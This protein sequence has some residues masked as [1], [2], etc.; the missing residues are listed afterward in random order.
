MMDHSDTSINEVYLLRIIIH[1]WR[2]SWTSYE[3]ILI[4]TRIYWKYDNRF[5]FRFLNFTRKSFLPNHTDET[6]LTLRFFPL[7]YSILLVTFFEAVSSIF[8]SPGTGCSA[9]LETA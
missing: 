9:H 7:S 4:F 1:L 8:P 5:V 2:I 3:D 6:E